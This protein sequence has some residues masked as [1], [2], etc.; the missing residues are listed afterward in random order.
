MRKNVMFS[1]AD[2]K[3]IMDC[4]RPT[5]LSYCKATGVY[6]S[7]YDYDAIMADSVEKVYKNWDSFDASRASFSTWVGFI[8]RNCASDHYEKEGRW[9]ARHRGF[10]VK[11]CKGGVYESEFTD[12]VCSEK[13]FADYDVMSNENLEIIYK[14]C[15]DLGEETGLAI[16]LLAQ[17]YNNREIAERLGCSDTALRARLMRGRKKLLQHPG[18]QA[19]R[20]RYLAESVAA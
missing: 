6:L 12:R 3:R 13:T 5:I 17:G 9:G 8:T 7:D 20:A 11:E 18:I 15:E 14:A 2:T 19:L 1:T 10:T 16:M 4:A